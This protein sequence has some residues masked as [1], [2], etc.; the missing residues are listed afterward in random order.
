MNFKASNSS[1]HALELSPND[2][3]GDAE[4]TPG[5]KSPTPTVLPTKRSLLDQPAVI[6]SAEGGLRI[7]PNLARSATQESSPKIEVQEIKREVIRLEQAVDA[8][9]RIERQFTFHEK[10]KHSK[11]RRS[12]KEESHSWGVIQRHPSRWMFGMAATVGLVVISS[13]MLLPAINAPNTPRADPRKG[14]FSVVNEEKVEGMEPLNLLLAQQTEAFQIFD[15]YVHAA[16]SDEVMPLIVNGR[17]LRETLRKYWRPL[18][19]PKDWA[20][21]VDCGWS[22]MEFGGRAYGLLQGRFPNHSEFIAY[23][24]FQDAHLLLDWKAT[25][26]FGTA[27]FTQLSEG[28]GDGSE[29]RG[30]LSHADFYSNT[31]PEA[32]YQSYRLTTPN[33]EISIWCYARRSEATHQVISPLFTSGE[34]SGE[35]QDLRKLTLSLTRGPAEGLPNQWLIKEMLHI[36]WGTH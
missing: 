17:A 19:L 4:D 7:E 3:W 9:A 15:S 10:P 8:P 31:W 33:E 32:D 30:S 13:L 1:N 20:P 25:T 29:I 5:E 18:E 12:L 23:F 21:S 35:S 28:A 11:T 24:T 26:A 16:H 2:S 14:L 6:G 34:I 22:V 36:D 27:T